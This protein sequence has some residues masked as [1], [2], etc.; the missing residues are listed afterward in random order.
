MS[1]TDVNVETG[2]HAL[3]YL[4]SFSVTELYSITF[5]CIERQES[6]ALTHS[7]L[8]PVLGALHPTFIPLQKPL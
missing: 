7:L 5:D 2:Q 8:M 1:P 4:P 6:K 3:L